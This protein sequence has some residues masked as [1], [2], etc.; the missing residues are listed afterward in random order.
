MAWD[1]CVRMRV[2]AGLLSG[3]LRVLRV[4]EELSSF[5]KPPAVNVTQLCSFYFC[6]GFLRGGCMH[7]VLESMDH[8]VWILC[9]RPG[10]YLLFSVLLH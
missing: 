1:G 9:Y 6:G 10:E 8:W 5:Q 2:E 7:L 3:I 4:G